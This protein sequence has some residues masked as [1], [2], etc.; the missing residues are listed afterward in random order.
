[1]ALEEMQFQYL[2]KI[3]KIPEKMDILKKQ[4]PDTLNIFWK[5]IWYDF[6]K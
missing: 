1:M 2:Y 5:H 3:N 6:S 4:I